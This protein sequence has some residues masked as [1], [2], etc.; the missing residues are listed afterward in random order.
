VLSASPSVAGLEN[1]RTGR[2]QKFLA[3]CFAASRSIAW[4]AVQDV[5]GALRDRQYRVWALCRHPGIGP[6]ALAKTLPSHAL[7]HTAEGKFF[8]EAFSKA[9]EEFKLSVTGIR[10]RDL[11][12]IRHLGV[13]RRLRQQVSSGPL[14]G[15]PVDHR[16]ENGGACR[17][18]RFPGFWI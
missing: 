8:R 3:N 15:T 18:N 9:C 14:L 5:V 1:F 11:D 17:S 13:R 16:S 12:A 10:E 7:I 2:T 6:P 4:A